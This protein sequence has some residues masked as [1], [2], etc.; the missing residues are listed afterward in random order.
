[1]VSVKWICNVKGFLFEILHM[2]YYVQLDG[3]TIYHLP[4]SLISILFMPNINNLYVEEWKRSLN[5][6]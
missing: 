2:E 1:M 4:L 3:Q 6:I 5:E